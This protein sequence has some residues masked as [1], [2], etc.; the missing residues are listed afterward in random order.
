MTNGEKAQALSYIGRHLGDTKLVKS[1]RNLAEID[2]VEETYTFTVT[3]KDV[4]EVG[5]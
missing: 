2:A 4:G 5:E 1:W 3:R